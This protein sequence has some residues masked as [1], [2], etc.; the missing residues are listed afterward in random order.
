MRR[1]GMLHLRE[2]LEI[3]TEFRSEN[4]KERDNLGDPDVDEIILNVP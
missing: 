3:H 1:A 2:R 4:L